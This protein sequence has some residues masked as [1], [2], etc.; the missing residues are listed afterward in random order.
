MIV[1]FCNSNEGFAQKLVEYI[2]DSEKLIVKAPYLYQLELPEAST[3]GDA[4]DAG[5]AVL[6]MF[7]TDNP[8]MFEEEEGE[9]PHITLALKLDS[10][11]SSDV[12]A[13]AS[14]P[15]VVCGINCGCGSW[16]GDSEL[17][18]LSENL[19]DF[20]VTGSYQ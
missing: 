6:G 16:N 11:D 18:E 15:I 14:F 5:L 20:L 4:L 8:D 9:E 13:V 1:E 7:Y 12:V 17:S 2:Q 3:P 19:I 10:S